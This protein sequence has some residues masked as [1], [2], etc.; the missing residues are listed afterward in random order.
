MDMNPIS[1][2]LAMDVTQLERVKTLNQQ[3]PD[4]GLKQA[5]EEFEAL[6]LHMMLKSMREASG[7]S[8]LFDSHERD[9]LMSM[10]DEQLSRHMSKQGIGLAEQL[11]QQLQQPST[12]R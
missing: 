6:F 1:N 12:K 4:A 5:A 11:V 2:Q 10:Y 7:P 9:T 3:N 8:E